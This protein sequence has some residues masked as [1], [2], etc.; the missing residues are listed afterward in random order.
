MKKALLTGIAVLF[1]ATGKT[2][3]R[4]R[5][6]C[7]KVKYKERSLV[8]YLP[9]PTSGLKEILTKGMP[10]SLANPLALKHAHKL[11]GILD[12]DS[13][14]SLLS[15]RATEAWPWRLSTLARQFGKWISTP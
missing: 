8:K 1:L 15:L 2:R 10:I 13:R 3:L 11:K 12:F 14:T 6:Y 5:F 9:H 7:P 4:R